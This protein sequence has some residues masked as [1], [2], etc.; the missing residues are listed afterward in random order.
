MNIYVINAYPDRADKYDNRYIMFDAIW[1]ESLSEEDTER[2]NFRHNC[3]M[4]LRKKITA[5]CLSHLGMIQKIIDEDLRNVMVLE[6]D[7]I[8]EDHQYAFEQTRV[9]KGFTYFGGQ[10]NSPLVKDYNTF[11]R[12]KK[13]KIQNS[14]NM[15]VVNP[16]KID[17]N[18]YRI[19][20]ACAYYIPNKEVSQEI[21]DAINTHYKDKKY[22]AI[23]VMFWE[24]QKKGIITD[25]IYPAPATLHIQDA[26]KGFTYSTYKLDDNQLHY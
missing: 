10:I 21:L 17:P 12:T 16:K 18:E 5:C 26:K 24:L 8:I 25:F 23:D 1:W 7:C 15:N 3:K 22:R 4:P 20:H 14:L 19:T 2:L 9:C 6:D 13:P 11:P